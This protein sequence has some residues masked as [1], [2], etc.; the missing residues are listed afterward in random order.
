MEVLLLRLEAGMTMAEMVMAV[1]IAVMLHY[2]KDTLIIMGLL[3]GG[4]LLFVP[5]LVAHPEK[6]RM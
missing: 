3:G 6:L 4:N 5:I 1:V 2:G